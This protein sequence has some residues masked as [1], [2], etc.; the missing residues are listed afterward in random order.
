MFSKVK[1]HETTIIKHMQRKQ[2]TKTVSKKDH[3]QTI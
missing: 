3:K 1:V 2:S